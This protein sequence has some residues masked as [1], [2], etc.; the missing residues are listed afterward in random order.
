MTY[1]HSSEMKPVVVNQ[2]DKYG[3]TV[4]TYV[5]NGVFLDGRRKTLEK[6]KVR[7]ATRSNETKKRGLEKPSKDYDMFL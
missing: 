2:L 7:T 1:C 6:Y 3:E 4:N 5:D